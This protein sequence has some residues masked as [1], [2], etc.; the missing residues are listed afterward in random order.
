MLTAIDRSKH[1]VK[2]TPAA[3]M[4]RRRL[5]CPA[6]FTFWNGETGQFILAYWV[7]ERRR[8]CDEI[9]DLGMACELVTPEFV[10][11][12]VSCWKPVN[13]K[14]KKAR[15]LSRER[16]RVRKRVEK[17][18]EDQMRWNWAQKRMV[19]KGLMPVPYAFSSPMSGGQVL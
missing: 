15:M 4:F 19:D 6:I 12:I 5:G 13:W 2:E 18:Q 8:L 16:D 14:V 3:K 11:M 9:E 17:I 7:D 10:N 1:V